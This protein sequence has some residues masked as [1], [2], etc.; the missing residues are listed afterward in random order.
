[1]MLRRYIAVALLVV[2]PWAWA[3]DTGWIYAG[4]ATNNNAAGTV[5]WTNPSNAVGSST[6]TYA[7]ATL[8]KSDSQ[9]LDLS[10]DLSAALPSGASI[11]GIEVALYGE[12][13]PDGTTYVQLIIEGTA[14]GSVKSGSILSSTPMEH[15]IGGATDLWGLTPTPDELKASTSGVRV[16]CSGGPTE[17]DF[18]VSYVG[19]K[20]Y[21]TPAAGDWWDTDWSHR[22]EGTIDAAYVDEEIPVVPVWVPSSATAWFSAVDTNGD[23][24]RVF[25]EDDTVELDYY[26]VDLDTAA[27]HCMLLVN[28]APIID[29]VTDAPFRVYA[30]NALAS[31]AS[32]GSA[33]FTGTGYAGYWMPGMSD[34]DLTGNGFGLTGVNWSRST[35]VAAS[36]WPGLD[37]AT[38]NGTDQRFTVGSAAVSD[39][40][41][42]LRALVYPTSDSTT[43][44]VLSVSDSG[45]NSSTI[46]V[47]AGGTISGDPQRTVVSGASGSV[48][49]ASTS[50][51]YTTN[52]WHD[53]A[54]SRNANTGN[55]L[56]YIDG[57]NQGSSSATVTAPAFDSMSI[58]GVTRTSSALLFPG[59]VAQADV[60]S[61]VR[62]AN[63]NATN[64]KAWFTAGFITWGS[65]ETAPSGGEN[66]T[67]FFFLF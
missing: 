51:G 67:N 64:H 24:I 42:S 9:Y 40:P 12:G 19:I 43:T 22:I 34:D 57:G 17:D 45:S 13:D 7:E 66:T 28:V 16:Q 18:R 23:D 58:G 38:F 11:D 31:A 65:V 44:V 50:S 30:G 49:N 25:N 2:A 14:S 29:T 10:H 21:Y 59:N 5:A 8:D 36:D 54:G 6:G 56:A 3:A 47:N 20:V 48:A 53:F 37:A 60:S 63:F 32:S 33:V 62:S 15:T 4:A 27:P 35:D 1:M 46:Y 52:T 26:I 61:V 55:T 41:V 39:W